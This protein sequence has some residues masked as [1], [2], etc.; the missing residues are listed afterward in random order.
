MAY[1]QGNDE[2]MQRG[3]FALRPSGVP[4]VEADGGDNASGEVLDPRPGDAEQDGFEIRPTIWAGAGFAWRLS[5]TG[6]FFSLPVIVK[7][8]PRFPSRG[9]GGILKGRL[10]PFPGA[11]NMPITIEAV[12]EN[13]ILKPA[14]PLPLKEHEKVRVT[15]EPV[16][17]SL[18]ERIVALA[19]ELP[20]EV[21]DSW[22]KD[23]ASQ[24]DHYLYGAPKRP[25]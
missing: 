2:T 3:G 10:A 18:A 17:P 8:R 16:Q 23:G 22:P 6:R 21:L 11:E 15:V 4:A 24:H 1:F 7:R 25:E 9:T 13:G 12:Y 20:P 5:R 14:Q 19:R